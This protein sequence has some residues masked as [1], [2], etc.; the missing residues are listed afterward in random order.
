MLKWNVLWCPFRSKLGTTEAVRVV[1]VRT[2]KS[3]P[4]TYKKLNTEKKRKKT[5]TITDSINRFFFFLEYQSFLCEYNMMVIKDF[6]L[7]LKIEH[8]NREVVCG[9]RLLDALRFSR[10][11]KHKSGAIG[12]FVKWP[13]LEETKKK[14]QKF[15]GHLSFEEHLSYISETAAT[16]ITFLDCQLDTFLSNETNNLGKVTWQNFFNFE[17]QIKSMPRLFFHFLVS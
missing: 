1:H 10:M 6:F 15:T 9:Q 5:L 12:L 16:K 17:K 13:S 11:M 14:Q 8:A 4:K 3:W 2:I 7:L